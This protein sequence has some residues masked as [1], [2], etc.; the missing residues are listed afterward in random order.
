MPRGRPRARVSPRPARAARAR[1]APGCTPRSAGQPLRG[2][3]VATSRMLV[4]AA[5][6]VLEEGHRQRS[7][8]YM[9]G[10]LPPAEAFSGSRPAPLRPARRPRTCAAGR[11]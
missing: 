8:T 2:R 1:A 6:T 4:A 9:G 5:L 7:L 10:V 11:G 3:Y